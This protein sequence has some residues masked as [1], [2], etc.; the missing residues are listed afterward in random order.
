MS[1]EKKNFENFV[2]FQESQNFNPENPYPN[3]H[4]C[5][6]TQP[7][8]DRYARKN[9]YRKSAGKCLDFIFGVKAGQG[10]RLQAIRYRL[11]EGWKASEARSDCKKRGGTFEAAKNAEGEND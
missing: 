3:E 9:C 11:K 4:A 2:D 8:Y 1:I 10:S 5:R 6:I 7:N